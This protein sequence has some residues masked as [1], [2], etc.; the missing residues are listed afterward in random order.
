LQTRPFFAV[1]AKAQKIGQ[2]LKT[3]ELGVIFLNGFGVI[4]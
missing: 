1:R 3:P 4:K 2:A